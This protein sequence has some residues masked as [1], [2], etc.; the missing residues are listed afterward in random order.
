[1]K[2]SVKIYILTLTLLGA[3]AAQAA[4][5]GPWPKEKAWAWYNAQPWIRGVNFVPSDCVNFV[6]QWQEYGFEE[7]LATAD[8]ELALAAD[9]GFNTVRLFLSYEVWLYE[10][11]GV[12]KRFDRY[13]D[14]CARHGIRAIVVLFNDC[15]S[16]KENFFL[17][18]MGD[19]LTVYKGL[20]VRAR[21]PHTGGPDVGYNILDIPEHAEKLCAMAEELIRLHAHDK[22]ILF[23]N[24]MNEPGYNNHGNVAAPWLRR[25]FEI[26]WKVDPDQPLA[27][28]LFGTLGR[29]KSNLAENVAAARSDIVSYHCYRDFAFQVQRIDYLRRRFGRPLINTEWMNR[30]T[31]NRFA[32][33]VAA[34][35]IVERAVAVALDAV[36]EGGRERPRLHAVDARHLPSVVP[37]LRS[38]RD[39][40]DQAFQ[41]AR[42]RGWTT[43]RDCGAHGA[44]AE[45]EGVGVVQRPAVDARVQLHARER[46]Q[47]HRHVAGIRQRGALCGDGPRVRPR[48]ENWF[49]RDALSC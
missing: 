36:R 7:R 12:L 6:D 47:L 28:D 23:W 33:A 10:R 32:C 38:A 41:Q 11:E 3:G 30:I 48:G 35:S 8:R 31:D 39:R 40:S 17:K 15:A 24:V 22:R 16:S 49:Q 45:G 13:L 14:V 27:A 2:T 20:G 25:L 9:T 5:T 46:R 21:S 34:A 37:S 19:Q 26:G 44:V 42:R 1:M 29:G 43:G 18:R 4:R